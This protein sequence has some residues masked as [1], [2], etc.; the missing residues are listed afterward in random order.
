MHRRNLIRAM[1]ATA[2]ASV[3]FGREAH[4]TLVRG[5]SLEELAG[6][7]RRI[8]VGRALDAT[9]HWVTLGGRRRIVTDTR[10][11]VEDVVAKEKPEDSE[12]LVRTL[13]GTVGD[14]GA[15]VHGEAELAY[16]EPCMVFLRVSSDGVHRVT[17]MAQG[18]YPIFPD[19]KRVLR[20]RASPRASEIV[21]NERIALRRL[22]GRELGEARVLVNEALR[23]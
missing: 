10:L 13:G 17:G 22:V 9:S 19:A 6:Q 11:R 16:D 20:L 4:A 1:G 8:L 5:L 18:H 12:I 23:R 7:S 2:L 3:G 21:G 15:L 14:V